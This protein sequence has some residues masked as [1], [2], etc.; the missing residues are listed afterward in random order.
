[1][2]ADVERKQKNAQRPRGRFRSPGN[3]TNAPVGLCSGPHVP[4]TE[5]K[6][7]ISLDSTPDVSEPDENSGVKSKAALGLGVS[8]V[9]RGPSERRPVCG[10]VR[11]RVERPCIEVPNETERTR[12]IGELSRLIREPTV[13]EHTRLAGLT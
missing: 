11:D 9:T 13:P 1:M 7:P 10:R 2:G 6:G 3:S 12:L 4:R 8:R 5:E